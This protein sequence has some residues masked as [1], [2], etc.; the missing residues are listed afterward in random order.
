MRGAKLNGED[1]TTADPMRFV[2]LSDG[3]ESRA[4]IPCN[5]PI[6]PDAVGKACQKATKEDGGQASK[7]RDDARGATS[8]RRIA[9]RRR[10]SAHAF[11]RKSRASTSS[12]AIRTATPISTCSPITDRSGSSAMALSISTPRFIGPG[13]MTMASGFA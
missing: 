2:H 11:R 3:R 5:S 13:C 12:T 1:E 4:P 10:T 7:D 9:L 8:R 6:L